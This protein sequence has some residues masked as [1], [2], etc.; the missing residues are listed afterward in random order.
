MNFQV[1]V[2]LTAQVNKTDKDPNAPITIN[3]RD[4]NKSTSLPGD[5]DQR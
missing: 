3:Y 2:S 1:I 4:E 5:K